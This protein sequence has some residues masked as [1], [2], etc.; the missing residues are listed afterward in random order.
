M[1]TAHLLHRPPLKKV[2]HHQQ[3]KGEKRCIAHKQM[4]ERSHQTEHHQVAQKP[5]GQQHGCRIMG[6]TIPKDAP[7]AI[8]VEHRSHTFPSV[9]HPSREEQRHQFQCI[10]HEKGHQYGDAPLTGLLHILLP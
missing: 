2:A 4:Y 7:S 1:G 10:P 9:V 6:I 3:D 5:C 8:R